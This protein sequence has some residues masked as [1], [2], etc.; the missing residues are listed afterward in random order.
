MD[1]R[2]RVR[3]VFD[4]LRLELV[5]SSVGSAWPCHQFA[6]PGRTHVSTNPGADLRRLPRKYDVKITSQSQTGLPCDHPVTRR[7]EVQRACRGASFI[8][9]STAVEFAVSTSR[10]ND[11]WAQAAHAC[12]T[13]AICKW[14]RPDRT[15]VAQQIVHTTTD[16]RVPCMK[17]GR[18]KRS[19]DPIIPVR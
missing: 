13:P 4:T 17:P 7:A 8:T 3:L 5:L 14:S 18:Q 12:A 1:L 11:I 16:T 2:I 19:T 6:W 15:T 9:T 10:Q